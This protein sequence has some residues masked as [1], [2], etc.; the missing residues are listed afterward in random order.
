MCGFAFPE[1]VGIGEGI[2]WG[3]NRDYNNNNTEPANAAMF[4]I[5]SFGCFRTALMLAASVGEMEIIELLLSYGVNTTCKDF[6]GFT[7]VDYALQL[8]HVG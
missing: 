1:L 6:S 5:S 3:V 7:A 8:G 4:H 2:V